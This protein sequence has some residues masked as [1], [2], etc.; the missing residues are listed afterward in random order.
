MRLCTLVI[1]IAIAAN[2]FAQT[3]APIDNFSVVTNL[4]YNGY[5]SNVLAIAEQRLAVNSN[6]LAGLILKMEFNLATNNVECFSNDIFSVLELLPH[7]SGE[8]IRLEIPRLQSDLLATLSFLADEYRPTHEEIEL[9]RAKFLIIHKP[10]TYEI[11]LK[12]L[13]DDGLF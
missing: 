8:N 1:A 3:N 11:P 10:M 6:D 7:V 13:H 5:K 9:D 4:W 12:A 2:A